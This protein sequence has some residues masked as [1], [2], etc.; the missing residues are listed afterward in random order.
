MK[1]KIVRKVEID[2]SDTQEVTSYQ[3]I[4]ATQDS[5]RVSEALHIKP[6]TVSKKKKDSKVT[7]FSRL[8]AAH[9]PRS[10]LG[11]KSCTPSL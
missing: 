4:T 5:K 8:G 3:G 7:H 1:L 9:I 2:K 11:A 10:R 6:T